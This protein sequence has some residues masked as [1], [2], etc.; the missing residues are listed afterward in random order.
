MTAEQKESDTFA[1][2]RAPTLVEQISDR[3]RSAIL[4]RQLSLG[5][6]L[7]E[8]K[9]ADQFGVSRGP[10]REAFGIL[11]A[12]GF[13]CSRDGGG[14]FV[15]DLSS[16]DFAAIIPVRASL[17]GLAAR[18]VTGSANAD[19]SRLQQ[20]CE[21]IHHTV[22][23]NNLARARDLVW[24]FHR[25]M[26]EKTGNAYLVNAWE[27]V[28]TPVRIFMHSN[29]IFLSD[30][31]LVLKLRRQILAIMHSGD[32][33]RAERSQAAMIIYHGFAVIGRSVPASLRGHVDGII[34]P[35]GTLL[36]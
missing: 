28:S 31:N 7:V 35:D 11:A 32:A 23:S 27:L 34:A 21:A 2:Q 12:E 24:E 20:L 5:E 18:L 33:D 1:I 13:V 3:L 10:L 16:D 22:D 29:N 14:T 8:K 25:T 36:N 30:I 19:L 17:E 26:I 6:R 9:I 4:G 15:V